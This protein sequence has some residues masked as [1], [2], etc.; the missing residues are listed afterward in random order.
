VVEGVQSESLGLF[1]PELT[2]PLERR[3]TAKALE[4]LRKVVRIEEGGQVR[5]KARMRGIE[6][7]ADRCVLDGPIHPFDLTVGPRM[8]EF[9]E[10]MVDAVL[11]T[12]SQMRA[13]SSSSAIS[14]SRFSR[15][16]DASRSRA[17]TS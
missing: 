10:P 16:C 11:S 8:V 14:L 9:R 13:R 5:S 6:E 7:P 3:E 1:C 4:S 15:R 17:S 12:R 2:T